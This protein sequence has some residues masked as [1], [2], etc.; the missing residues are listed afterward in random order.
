MS[1]DRDR[2]I[3]WDG[4]LLSGWITV[5]GRPVKVS[6]NRETIHRHAPG[7]NDALTWEIERHRE[8]IF[9]KL[10]PFFRAQYT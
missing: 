4:N 7:W 6:A 3:V 10:A 8:E 2:A 9:N 1:V 5:E